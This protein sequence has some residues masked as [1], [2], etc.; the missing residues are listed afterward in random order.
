MKRALSLVLTVCMLLSTV[1][2]ALPVSAANAVTEA[3]VGRTFTAD[4]AVIMD[5]T[6]DKVPHTYEAWIKVPATGA[7]GN[8]ISNTIKEKWGGTNAPRMR[9][10]IDENGAPNL[11][12]YDEIKTLYEVDFD[13]VNVNTGAWTHLAIVQEADNTFSCYVNGT[14]YTTSYLYYTKY[15]EGTTDPIYTSFNSSFSY[16]EIDKEVFDMPLVIG[17]SNERSNPLPFTGEIAG[18]T[19][20]ADARTAAEVA[21]DMQSINASD[22]DLLASYDLTKDSVNGVYKNAKS[23][24]IDLIDGKQWLT[25]TEMEAVRAQRF[26]GEFERAY[27]LVVVGDTQM[28]TRAAP[29]KLPVLYNW[30]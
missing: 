30:I 26:D 20:Y 12:W 4:D 21:A 29:D 24:G 16:P 17:G 18:V 25:E 15:K 19:M 13:T 1:V 9:L 8:I 5:G 14:R 10:F 3:T 6:L 7:T 2:F 22:A 11:E 23:G 27:S 28:T